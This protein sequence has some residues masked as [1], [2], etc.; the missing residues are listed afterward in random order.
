M[1]SLLKEYSA[2]AKY[3]T[4][5][6]VLYCTV[7]YYYCTLVVVCCCRALCIENDISALQK[8]TF[9]LAR[10]APVILIFI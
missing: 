6:T 10:F 9:L 2:P 1:Q 4:L 7:L 3:E 8:A 5:I